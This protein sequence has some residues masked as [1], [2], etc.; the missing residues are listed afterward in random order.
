MPTRDR[1]EI[2]MDIGEDFVFQ[3]IWTDEDGLPIPVTTPCRAD[4]KDATGTVVVSYRTGN[5][6][7]TQAT[8][9]VSSGTQ[10]FMQ[11]SIP[12]AIT[13]TLTPGTYT[14]DLW[15]T[16]ND[17]TSPISGQQVKVFTAFVIAYDRVTVM[18]NA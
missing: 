9:N 13:R 17:A 5:T 3:V 1:I 16:V 12:R 11:L 18:E 14:M 10:G 8:I 15:A 6:V 4:I 2:N 7:G